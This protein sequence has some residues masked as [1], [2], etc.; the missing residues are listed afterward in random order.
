MKSNGDNDAPSSPS[1]YT[2]T[3]SSS[4]P[5]WAP[6][7]TNSLCVLLLTPTSPNPTNTTVTPAQPQPH[8][9]TPPFLSTN[10]NVSQS[11]V[12]T[13]DYT[14]QLTPST[15]YATNEHLS[16]V[17][18]HVDIALLPTINNLIAGISGRLDLIGYDDISSDEYFTTAAKLLTIKYIRH[19]EMG[20]AEIFIICQECSSHRVCKN[21]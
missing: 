20:R 6:M 13:S 8:L 10:F 4:S 5:T 2:V 12:P 21:R 14:E 16:P 11:T 7:H 1:P 15:A 17:N 19:I 3:P 18:G 9:A